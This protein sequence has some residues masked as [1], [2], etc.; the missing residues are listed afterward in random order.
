MADYKTI[1]GVKYDKSLIEA[2]E[3]AIEGVGDGRISFDDAKTIWADAME[4]GKITR[5]EDRTLKYILENYNVTDKAKAYIED[6]VF[7]TIGGV[8]YDLSLLG[9]ADKL[10]SGQGDGRISYDDAG[11]IWGLADADGI[12]TDVEARTI[13]YIVENYNATDKAKNWLLEQLD[14]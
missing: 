8:Q 11:V 13:R 6:K 1:D 2:A 7:K 14:K 10:T 5:V 12:I 3:K 9:A 4:D